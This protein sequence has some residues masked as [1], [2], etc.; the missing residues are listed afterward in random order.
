MVEENRVDALEPRRAL[1]DQGV[2]QAY[3]AAQLE[4]VGWR[5]PRLGKA[6]L[7]EELAQVARVEAVGLRTALGSAAGPGVR[8]LGQV[9]LRG[10]ALELLA[11]EAPAGG[12]LERRPDRLA[13]EAGQEAPEI[14]AIGGGDAPGLDLPRLLVKRV[15]GDLSA[16]DVEADGEG[17]GCSFSSG[18]GAAIV[19]LW[20]DGSCHMPSFCDPK[21]QAGPARPRGRRGPEKAGVL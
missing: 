5:D 9:D 16:V 10:D 7:E 17:H 4:D 11:D 12:G 3:L 6:S 13:R 14:G 2:A 19:R 21:D 20:S 8:R 18:A 15:E 1:I